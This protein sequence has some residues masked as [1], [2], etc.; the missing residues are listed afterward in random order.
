MSAAT[1][2]SLSPVVSANLSVLQS[3]IRGMLLGAV[4]GDCFGT[5]FCDIGVNALPMAEVAESLSYRAMA[6]SLA[7]LSGGQ[8]L[9]R[10]SC[11]GYMMLNATKN[12]L[13]GGDSAHLRQSFVDLINDPDMNHLKWGA[14]IGS[15]LPAA[16]FPDGEYETVFEQMA[17]AVPTHDVA[18]D[19]AK[20]LVDIARNAVR[21]GVCDLSIIKD[22]RT[23]SA[24]QLA[25]PV[26]YSEVSMDVQ[27]RLAARIGNDSMA[28]TA[29]PIVAFAIKQGL[30]GEEVHGADEDADLGGATLTPAML[31]P[32]I[33]N[34]SNK[35]D[36]AEQ[37][38]DETENASPT[39]GQNEMHLILSWAISCGGDTRANACLAG[40][41]AGATYGAEQ[42]P[43]EWRVTCE[44]TKEALRVA[45]RVFE[46]VYLNNPTLAESIA[47][48]I[49]TPVKATAE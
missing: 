23:I 3:R 40:A 13:N 47:R 8:W 39:Y 22:S 38:Y 41:I 20:C 9:F 4:V 35:I 28:S 46:E 14:G 25:T 16:L 30:V 6:P 11:N 24:L 31:C 43:H 32:D 12:V 17:G 18:K 36:F 7:K 44:G 2:K 10:Q 5:R 33:L 15:D 37:Y 26:N 42:I 45:D 34:S 48:S 29:L 21:T 19:R 1:G 49:S 27:R